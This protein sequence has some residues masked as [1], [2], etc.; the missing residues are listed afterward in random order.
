MG[1]GTP[2]CCTA[3]IVFGVL[4]GCGGSSAVLSVFDLWVQSEVDAR[5]VR[6]ALSH[7]RWLGEEPSFRGLARAP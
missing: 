2:H 7:S 4:D 5:S 1:C 6:G 3:G